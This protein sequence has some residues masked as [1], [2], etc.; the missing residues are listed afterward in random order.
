MRVQAAL[1]PP[2]LTL[3]PRPPL[4]AWGRLIE[5]VDKLITRAATLESALDGSMGDGRLLRL[6]RLKRNVGFDAMPH[7][8]FI[9]GQIAAACACAA[10][11]VR[12]GRGS[13]EV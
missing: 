6:R 8:R 9:Y 11:A 12:H 10:A 13:L 1:E 4:H 5:A 2:L 7:M 3:V